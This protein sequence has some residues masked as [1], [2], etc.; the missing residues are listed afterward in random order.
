MF[1]MAGLETGGFW[2]KFSST[3]YEQDVSL[4]APYEVGSTPWSLFVNNR[5]ASNQL[6]CEQLFLPPNEG[7]HQFVF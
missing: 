7:T 2:F 1:Y 4:A 3:C 5:S 6:P